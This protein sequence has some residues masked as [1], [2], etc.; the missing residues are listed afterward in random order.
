MLDIRTFS[1]PLQRLLAEWIGKLADRLLRFKSQ[2]RYGFIELISSSVAETIEDNLHRPFEKSSPTQE[3]E[4]E[5]WHPQYLTSD[6]MHYPYPE[7]PIRRIETV[8]GPNHQ[9]KNE[10]WL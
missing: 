1:R 6:R 8:S 9:I 7:R 3:L 10:G 2:L 4:D 5:S